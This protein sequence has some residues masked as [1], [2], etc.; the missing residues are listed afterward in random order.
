M[1]YRK[2]EV[3]WLPVTIVIGLICYWNYIIIIIVLFILTGRVLSSE[4]D[5]NQ[6]VENTSN[7]RMRRGWSAYGAY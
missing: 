2:W 5:T 7:Q 6:I 4:V 3:K 1:S